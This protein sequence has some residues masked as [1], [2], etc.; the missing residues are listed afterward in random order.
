MFSLGRSDWLPRQT[1]SNGTVVSTFVRWEGVPAAGALRKAFLIRIQMSLECVRRCITMTHSTH[2]NRVLA[3]CAGVAQ[4][5]GARA[6]VE[7]LQD[8]EVHSSL[9]QFALALGQDDTPPGVPRE[10]EGRSRRRA[11]PKTGG[12]RRPYRQKHFLL[13]L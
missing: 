8:P 1:R 12:Q 13:V 4:L 6:I 5:S 2:S 9:E 11:I 7:A 10:R 3:C